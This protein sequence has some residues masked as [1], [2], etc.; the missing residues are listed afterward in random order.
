MLARP[1]S[2]RPRQAEDF[3]YL[4]EYLLTRFTTN[5]I[6]IISWGLSAGTRSGQQDEVPRD[7]LILPLIVR[8]LRVPRAISR[9][10][11]D[12]AAIYLSSE[13]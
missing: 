3:S 4:K 1:V 5:S 11:R 13:T 9:D 8:V 6:I 12:P 10:V 7:P 2:D